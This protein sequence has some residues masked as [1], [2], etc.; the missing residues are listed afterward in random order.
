MRSTRLDVIGEHIIGNKGLFEVYWDR[1]ATDAK[2]KDY[3]LR[4]DRVKMMQSSRARSSSLY[5]LAVRLGPPPFPSLS[6]AEAIRRISYAAN[7]SVASADVSIFTFERRLEAGIWF[8][9]ANR[10]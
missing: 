8:P 6:L 10:I 3:R 7:F 9:S 2:G 5:L 4:E 1:G